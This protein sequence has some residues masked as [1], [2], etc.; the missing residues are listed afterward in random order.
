MRGNLLVTWISMSVN[1][2]DYISYQIYI[3]CNLL[4]SS[5]NQD[6]IKISEKQNKR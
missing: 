3:G 1:V 6:K 5:L 2:L 4:F